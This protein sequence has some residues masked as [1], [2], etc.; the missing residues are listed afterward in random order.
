M[1]FKVGANFLLV[2]VCLTISTALEERT[3]AFDE[4]A[5]CEN[6]VKEEDLR[7]A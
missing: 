5:S 6:A 7:G 2:V 1:C 3:I 4:L